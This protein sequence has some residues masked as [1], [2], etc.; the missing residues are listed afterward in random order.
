ME[1]KNSSL[2]RLILFVLLTFAM[3]VESFFFFISQQRDTLYLA[4]V[5]QVLC[6]FI[7]GYLFFYNQNGYLR[8]LF[9]MICNY[10]IVVPICICFFTKQM[11]LYPLLLY[12][13]P[14][15]VNFCLTK[16]INQLV[17]LNINSIAV[18]AFSQKHLFYY[19]YYEPDCGMSSFLCILGVLDSF[20]FSI[21]FMIVKYWLL[22]SDKTDLS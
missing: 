5:S 14:I 12:V 16:N 10:I 2:K 9:Q 17:L 19:G 13:I 18:T 4:A 22:L 6:I 15:A 8:V 3:S 1:Q 21:F 7:V 20:M 11:V